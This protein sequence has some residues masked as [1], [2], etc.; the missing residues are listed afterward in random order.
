MVREGPAE[1]PPPP[2]EERYPAEKARGGDII[3]D[4]PV[5]RR[6]FIAGLAGAVALV[7]VLGILR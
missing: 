2:K 4:T 6:I 3:L 1:P 5:K 7:L